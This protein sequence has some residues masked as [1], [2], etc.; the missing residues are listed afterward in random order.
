MKTLHL[1]TPVIPGSHATA[2]APSISKSLRRLLLIGAAAVSPELLHAQTPVSFD[3]YNT[4]V[5]MSGLLALAGSVDLHYTQTVPL[6]TSQSTY[7][8][9]NTFGTIIP[10]DWIPNSVASESNGSKWITPTL[11]PG[12]GE[13]NVPH[14]FH[15]TFDLAGLDPDTARLSGRWAGDDFSFIKLN[16]VVKSIVSNV[17][18]SYSA[19]TSFTITDGFIPGSNTLDFVGITPTTVELGPIGLRVQFTEHTALPVPEPGA[20]VLA[21]SSLIGLLARRRR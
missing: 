12:I 14:T 3:C 11:Y 6:T 21:S 5:L 10:A 8:S 2:F 13:A 20:L 4:G 16:G 15:T 17:P 9:G 19:W 7:V 18:N 1:T